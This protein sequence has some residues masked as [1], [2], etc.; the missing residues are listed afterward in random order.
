MASPACPSRSLCTRVSLQTQFPNSRAVGV[1]AST[2]I[3]A[4]EG[5]SYRALNQIAKHC[6][7]PPL[8]LF[9]KLPVPELDDF[10]P[11]P[12]A[13][14]SDPKGLH[15]VHAHG[16]L[17][18][19]CSVRAHMCR[20][21]PRAPR[22]PC[23]SAGR[24]AGRSG[25][26]VPFVEGKL[27]WDTP[28]CLSEVPATYPSTLARKT[29]APTAPLKAFWAPSA[30]SGSSVSTTNGTIEVTDDAGGAIEGGAAS[31][32][33]ATDALRPIANPERIHHLQPHTT[34]VIVDDC[35]GPTSYDCRPTDLE[36]HPAAPTPPS[37]R[38][39]PLEESG[40]VVSWPS[41]WRRPCLLSS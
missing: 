23:R 10:I 4:T 15:L 24:S 7:G 34:I 9:E 27:W 20:G 26:A 13:W 16:T 22:A 6:H 8:L 21:P 14:T 38:K 19:S 18:P 25:P 31:R 3:G 17:V 11:L 29:T 40:R 39:R 30:K 2:A 36:L 37:S 41:R 33:D 28:A 5:Y 32:A 35:R 1:W 12:T